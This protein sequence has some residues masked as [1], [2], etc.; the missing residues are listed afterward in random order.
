[1]QA[2]S[3]RLTRL[4]GTDEWRDVFYHQTKQQ[5]LFGTEDYIYRDADFEKISQF[6]VMRLKT[7]F[8]AVSEH[9]L[10]LRNSKNNPLYL[11]CFAAGNP[12]G[13]ATA[14]RIAN[15]LLRA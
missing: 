5:I 12:T 9:P 3:D 8:P 10:P 14:L 7:I 2:W 11:L 4:F 13:S 1:M 6:V 15:Y